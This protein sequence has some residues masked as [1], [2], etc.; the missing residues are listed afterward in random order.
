MKLVTSLCFC[1]ICIFLHGQEVTDK[2]LEGFDFNANGNLSTIFHAEYAATIDRAAAMMT[3]DIPSFQPEVMITAPLGATHFRIKSAGAAIDFPGDTYRVN[4]FQS[5]DFSLNEPLA[6]PLRITHD[7]LLPNL[8]LVL[9]LGIEFVQ[10][11]NN[12]PKPLSDSKTSALAIVKVD[13]G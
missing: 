7:V 3:I 4:S 11:V 9:V 5:Q 1:C 12:V 10:I 2:I 8:P 6:E 13:T